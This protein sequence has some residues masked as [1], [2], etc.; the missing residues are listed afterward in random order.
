M[1]IV[2]RSLSPDFQSS[3]NHTPAVVPV[4]MSLKVIHTKRDGTQ[5]PIKVSIWDA[6]KGVPDRKPP[7]PKPVSSELLPISS[8]G[9]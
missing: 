6:F 3:A 9:I 4:K 8:I 5:V 7:K 1:S 2:I